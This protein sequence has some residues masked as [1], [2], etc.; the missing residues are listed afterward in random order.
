MDGLAV[1]LK[2]GPLKLLC[3]LQA[4]IS[5]HENRDDRQGQDRDAGDEHASLRNGIRLDDRLSH[6]TA[7]W[8]RQ[9]HSQ[10]SVDGGRLVL[11]P[12]GQVLAQ[13]SGQRVGPDGPGDGR[14]DTP[15]D[16]GE[17]AHQRVRHGDVLVLARRHGG[18]L[19][20]DDQGAA[21]EGLEDLAHD[22]VADPAGRVAEVD[23]QADSQEHDGHGGQGE[24]LES[25]GLA[26]HSISR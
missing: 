15:T 5:P 26:D 20:A 13:L 17:E 10:R 7:H 21:R 24:P 6:G 23:H 2:Y 11:A 14:A 4:D 9:R 25:T 16:P 3:L 12:L 22:D 1:A 18:H 8:V 19:G